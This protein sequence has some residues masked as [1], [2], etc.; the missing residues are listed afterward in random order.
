MDLN[1]N[2]LNLVFSNSAQIEHFHFKLS[3]FFES[4]TVC[5]LPICNYL[6]LK[7]QF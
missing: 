2:N 7:V 1:L 6:Y 3:C 4:N 5:G